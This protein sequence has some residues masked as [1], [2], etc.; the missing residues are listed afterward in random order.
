M[1]GLMCAIQVSRNLSGHKNATS[2][3]VYLS[4]TALSQRRICSKY[5]N[6]MF[7][8]QSNSGTVKASGEIKAARS[9]HTH[10]A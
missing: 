9:I 4:N 7:Q 8:R 10:H 5:N 1:L 6:P 3:G 2:R